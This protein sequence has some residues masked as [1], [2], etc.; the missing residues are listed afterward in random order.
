MDAVTDFFVEGICKFVVKINLVE[1]L[2]GVHVAALEEDDGLTGVAVRSLHFIFREEKEC[3][4]ERGQDLF[5]CVV[6]LLSQFDLIDG[7]YEVVAYDICVG[8]SPLADFAHGSIE[9]VF[10]AKLGQD[11][12]KALFCQNI[13]HL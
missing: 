2:H 5:E 6:R 3:L 11:P 4:G 1:T 12:V 13:T 9:P 10:F 8:K 7:L